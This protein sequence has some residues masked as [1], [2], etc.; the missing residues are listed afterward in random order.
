MTGAPAP[1]LADSA[2]LAPALAS[3]TIASACATSIG[4]CS[5]GKRKSASSSMRFFETECLA[6]DD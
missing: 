2:A 5:G 6:V 3:V 1:A 4:S